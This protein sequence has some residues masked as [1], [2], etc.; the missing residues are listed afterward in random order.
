MTPSPL[1][2]D[3]P[4]DNVEGV[5]WV[6]WRGSQKVNSWHATRDGRSTLCNLPKGVWGML[7]VGRPYGRCSHCLKAVER[8]KAD[9][10][11]A[12]G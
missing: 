7:Y 6:R 9:T 3:F 10:P 11:S 2:T 1:W 4:D 12:E 8:L 5:Y